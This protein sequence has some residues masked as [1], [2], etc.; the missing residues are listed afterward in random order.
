MLNLLDR[1]VQVAL[2]DE[3]RERLGQTYSPSVSASQSRFYTGYGSFTV[4]ASIDTGELEATR[5]AMIA[6]IARLR[7]EP[8]DADLIQRA[9]QPLMEAF[10]NALVTNEG[11]IGLVDRAQTEP[12]RIARYFDT[13]EYLPTV[14]GEDIRAMALRYLDPAERLEII[15]LPRPADPVGDE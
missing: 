7:D 1:V 14:T 12:E 5:E 2:T 10:E 3:L 13:K 11:L 8:I 6:A 15:V 9:R 4:V